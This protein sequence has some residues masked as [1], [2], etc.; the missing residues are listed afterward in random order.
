MNSGVNG[1]SCGRAN[2]C[3]PAKP[4]KSTL[5]I[6]TATAY[7]MTSPNSTESCLVLPFAITWNTR[8]ATSETVPNSR[9]SNDA[10]SSAPL[11]PPNDSAPTP[12][13]E[14][15]MDVTTTAA[16]MGDMMRRQYFANRPSPPS[17]TPPTMMAPMAV[18]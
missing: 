2:S 15:P 6:R 8:H 14:N 1:M 9:F 13:S 4:P 17:M 7:P 11:P 3:R 18:L 12:S 16:T 5:P 10:K